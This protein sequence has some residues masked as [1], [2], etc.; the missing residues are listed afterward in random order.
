[1]PS[2]GVSAARQPACNS[3]EYLRLR[4]DIVCRLACSSVKIFRPFFTQT[5]TSRGK[6]IA[7]TN[8]LDSFQDVINPD[9]IVVN[10]NICRAADAFCEVKLG[11]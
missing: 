7:E 5:F 10:V 1:M 11:I 3:L 4:Y 8:G 6:D 2:A 9:V